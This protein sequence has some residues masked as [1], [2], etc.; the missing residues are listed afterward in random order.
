M[1]G[2][3][4]LL[5]LTGGAATLSIVTSAMSAAADPQA[6]GVATRL[7]ATISRE[8]QARE[9]KSAERARA[10]KLREQMV[11]ATENR[12]K[13]DITAR[14]EQDKAAAAEQ[15]GKPEGPPQSNQFDVLARVYQA[16]KPNKAAPVFEQLDL[17]VQV[18]VA[19]RMRERSTAMIMAAMSPVA[20]ARLS[21][22]MAGKRPTVTAMR[23]PL[24]TLPGAGAAP[25]STPS[26]AAR[27][28]PVA[29]QPPANAT[30]SEPAALPSPARS[31]PAK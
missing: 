8:L 17:D 14:S 7:G 13:A 16:M 28:A 2:R 24:P 12:L 21:M 23:Q 26:R 20:A 19:K 18:A 25:I 30:V 22:A 1:S 11:K 15:A 31:A 9:A 10:L 6:N 27:P 4:W 29:V 5:I 3:P